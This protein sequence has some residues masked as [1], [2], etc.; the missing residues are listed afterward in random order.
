M[1]IM[2]SGAAYLI[3]L[4]HILSYIPCLV[5][6]MFHN[7][8]SYN[9]VIIYY[10]YWLHAITLYPQI[11]KWILTYWCVEISTGLESK[12][13]FFHQLPQEYT[14]IVAMLQFNSETCPNVTGGTIPRPQKFHSHPK[15]VEG[16]ALFLKSVKSYLDCQTS[17]HLSKTK[18]LMF[19]LYHFTRDLQRS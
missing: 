12:T 1:M 5:E 11:H 18:H 3:H 13:G 4:H 14:L 16:N 8:T 10:D 9:Y 6:N 2:T 15:F 7:C 17:G 19:L